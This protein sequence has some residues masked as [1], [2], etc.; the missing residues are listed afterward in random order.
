MEKVLFTVLVVVVLF[1]VICAGLSSC[2]NSKQPDYY[3]FT[4]SFSDRP[5]ITVCGTEM[6]TS[7]ITGEHYVE[8]GNRYVVAYFPPSATVLITKVDSCK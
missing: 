6:I 2:V 1:A 7:N 5:T 8:D 4:A 3:Q